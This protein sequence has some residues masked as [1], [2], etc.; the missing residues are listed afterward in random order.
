MNFRAAALLVLLAALLVVTAGTQSASAMPDSLSVNLSTGPG[1]I[2]ADGGT[3]GTLFL[4]TENEA[5]LP[6]PFPDNADTEVSLW[7]SDPDLFTV[8]PSLIVPA[9]SVAVS[10]PVQTTLK[11]GTGTITAAVK[12]EGAASV[13]LQT[14]SSKGASPAFSLKLELAPPTMPEGS[15]QPG[16]F[17]VSLRGA[18]GAPVVAP[19]DTRIAITSSRPGAA[20]PTETSYT[21][22]AGANAVFGQYA[23][24]D[25]GSA[26]FTAQANGFLTD[27]QNV[28]ITEPA[29]DEIISTEPVE[30]GEEPL[31]EFVQ[32]DASSLVVYVVPDRF[33]P[34]DSS[35]LIVAQALAL[36]GNPTLFS[37]NPVRV[38]TDFVNGISVRDGRI[39][40]PDGLTCDANATTCGSGGCALAAFTRSIA[41]SPAVLRSTRTNEA[42]VL[43][44]AA[45]SASVDRTTI[46]GAPSV[47]AVEQIFVSKIM[48]AR[49]A[50]TP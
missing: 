34:G 7:T 13:T 38:T 16:R 15:T 43:E 19:T 28:T 25:Q 6:F 49:T 42:P 29:L 27:S 5:G 35:A 22:P 17:V 48:S 20:A 41:E 8:A 9:G 11:A 12:N 33:L 46:A 30:E 23:V 40:V 18:E 47:L 2:L 44:I 26:A 45:S 37:C 21:I 3:S 24:G 31:I 4:R 39:S 32:S 14:V 36:S 10:I 1:A 50:T